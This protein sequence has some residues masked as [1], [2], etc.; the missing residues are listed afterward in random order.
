MEIFHSYE[1]VA[2][3]HQPL[4][5]GCELILQNSS[6]ASFVLENNGATVSQVVIGALV[7]QMYSKISVWNF[8]NAN[9]AFLALIHHLCR[10]FVHFVPRALVSL[11]PMTS[12]RSW[13]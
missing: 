7:S 4:D 3:R 10:A 6:R 2:D 5:D 8:F 11:L 12:H 1:V 13:P 9:M